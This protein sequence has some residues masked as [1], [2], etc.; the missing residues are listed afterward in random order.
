[1][2]MLATSKG[3]K[4]KGNNISREERTNIIR[5]GLNVWRVAQEGQS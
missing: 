1:M 5:Q 2:R 4:K 3:G